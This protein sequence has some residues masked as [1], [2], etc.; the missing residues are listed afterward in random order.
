MM[1]VMVGSSAVGFP[2]PL[3]KRSPL[4]SDGTLFL[5]QPALLWRWVETTRIIG[6]L[7][8]QSRASLLVPKL[9]K[10]AEGRCAVGWS[11]HQSR[12][13]S[14]QCF[15]WRHGKRWH[16]QWISCD[17]R[18][19]GKTSACLR[20]TLEATKLDSNRSDGDAVTGFDLSSTKEGMVAATFA[21]VGVKRLVVEMTE[22]ETGLSLTATGGRWSSE[23]VSP[24]S[25]CFLSFGGSGRVE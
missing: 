5:F 2:H 9:S 12:Q 14:A 19:K 13:A 15:L 23:H 1:K 8:R 6:R 11:C 7:A 22:T 16:K 25:C 18:H 20:R 24:G 21:E 4:Q 17:R 3:S 10:T